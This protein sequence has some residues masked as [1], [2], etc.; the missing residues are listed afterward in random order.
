MLLQFVRLFRIDRDVSIFCPLLIANY[1]IENDFHALMWIKMNMRACEVLL[2]FGYGELREWD[3]CEIYR[4][5]R[6]PKDIFT[7]CFLSIHFHFPIVVGK[8]VRVG[9]LVSKFLVCIW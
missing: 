9:F 8:C 3:D 2:F 7:F 6:I 1:R 5:W 4:R